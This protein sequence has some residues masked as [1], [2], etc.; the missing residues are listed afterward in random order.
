MN[1]ETAISQQNSHQNSLRN[2][3][4]FSSAYLRDLKNALQSDQV[5]LDD[6]ASARQTIGEWR[7]EYHDFSQTTH[8]T[9]SVKQSLSALGVAFSPREDGFT[10]FADSDKEHATGLCL[11]VDDDDLGRAVKGRHHQVQLVRELRSAN[12]GWG[13][14]TNGSHWR[15]CHAKAA[16]PYEEWLEV[17]LDGLLQESAVAPFAVFTRLFGSEAWRKEIGARIGL[18]ARL[19][20]SQKRT[21]AV[22]RHLKSRVEKILER[23]CLGFVADENATLANAANKNATNAN[24]TMKVRRIQPVKAISSTRTRSWTRFIATRPICCIAFCLCFTPKRATCCRLKTR[25]MRLSV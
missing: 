6:F 7:E 4:L 23:L 1:E 9:E 3:Q 21:E 14:L 25:R 24:A 19:N 15:L 16:A 18:D 17:D 20:E 12:L 13:V 10:L 11:C 5:N 2:Q 22:E 8:R